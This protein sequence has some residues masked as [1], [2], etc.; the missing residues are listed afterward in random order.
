[1]VHAYT[2]ITLNIYLCIE[3]DIKYVYY[4]NDDGDRIV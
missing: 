2:P 3:Q 1:M 4:G